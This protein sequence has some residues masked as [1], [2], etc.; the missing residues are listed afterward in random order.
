[1]PSSVRTIRFSGF[2]LTHL[3]RGATC[4]ALPT[5][6]RYFYFNSRT[7]CEV[8]RDHILS[9]IAAMDFNS[10]TSCEVRHDAPGGNRPEHRDFN[11]RTSCEVRQAARRSD[12]ELH[13]FQLTHLLRGATPAPLCTVGFCHHFNSR[14]SCE[15]RPRSYQS[16]ALALAISTHAPLARCDCYVLALHASNEKFQLTHLLRGATRASPHAHIPVRISTHAPLARCDLQRFVTA[17]GRKDFNS[18]TSCE[19][20]PTRR[21]ANAS[22]S[23]FQLTHLLRGATQSRQL[24]V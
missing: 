9:A 13:G 10:R 21:R 19:V 7:S 5:P 23:G 11:S 8:R 16:T 12:V 1:M 3:L 17:V 22:G 2:Q 18:R 4:A 15:M 14:T 6:L 20:R 24:D